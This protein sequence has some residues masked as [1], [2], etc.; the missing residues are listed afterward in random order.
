MFDRQ[1]LALSKPVVD[2]SARWLR[3]RGITANQ[4]SIGGFA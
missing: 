1:M 2:S 4:I 3:A